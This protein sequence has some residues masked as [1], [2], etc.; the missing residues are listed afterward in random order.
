MTHQQ[1]Q[2]RLSSEADMGSSGCG[3]SAPPSETSDQGSEMGDSGVVP[4]QNSSHSLHHISAKVLIERD[5]DS[6][7]HSPSPT[8]SLGGHDDSLSSDSGLLV[9]CERGQVESFF[10]GL[11]TEVSGS[12]EPDPD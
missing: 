9:E 1:R 7:L 5:A 2:Q 8:H 10:S 12:L 11:G 4:N 6:D 3:S